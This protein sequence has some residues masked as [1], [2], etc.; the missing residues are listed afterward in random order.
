MIVKKLIMKSLFW[1]KYF[2]LLFNVHFIKI[3]EDELEGIETLLD[4]G[5]GK[6]SIIGKI[7]K[8]LKYTVGIDIFEQDIELSK[9]KK[10]HDEYM[11]LDILDIDSKIPSNSFDC[12][13]LMDVI[14]HLEKSDGI[15]L[16]QKMEKIAKKKI[17]I[18]TPNGFLNQPEYHNNI[19]QIHRS[20]WKMNFFKKMNFK[21]YGINGLKFIR[22]ELARIKR[23]PI[24]FWGDISI[25]SNLFVKFFPKF[26]FQLLCIK[27]L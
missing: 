8:K 9:K 20:G 4:L 25:I 5:C 3:F 11:L 13:I 2:T 23:R 24:E 7:K 22:G 26:A 27:N 17:I 19:H 6:D 10:I 14:E 15:K 16:I 12:V 1:L 21:V 18:F